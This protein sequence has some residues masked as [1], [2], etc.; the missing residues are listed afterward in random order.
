MK[1]NIKGFTLIELIIVIAVIA[2]LAAI[3]F[4]AV[5]PARR[6]GDANNDQRWADITA[7]A[8][9]WQKST[10]DANGLTP[11]STELQTVYAIAIGD[12]TTF[13]SDVCATSENGVPVETVGMIDL[14]SLTEDGYLGLLPV[15]PTDEVNFVAEGQTGYYFERPSSNLIKV[16]A[17]VTYPDNTEEIFVTR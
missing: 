1:K 10:A 2:I 9:A 17:C 15:E 14:T 8:E 5:N 12:D 4:V 3:A 6:I 13:T 16:G 7:L 11:T